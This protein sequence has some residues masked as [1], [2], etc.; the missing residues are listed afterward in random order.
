[1]LYLLFGPDDFSMKEALKGIKKELGDASLLE[2]NT[3]VLDGQ[4]ISPGEMNTVVGA[5]PFLAEKRLVIINGLLGRFQSGRESGRRRDNSQKKEPKDG[6]Q[7]F[8][9]IINNL[10]KSTVLVL[11]DE[12]MK[13]ENRSMNNILEILMLG[14][15]SM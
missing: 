10:P 5:A 9:N 2:T 4:K 13:K 11:V 14:D 15:W 3:N 1:M 6:H 8:T 7:M 12:E